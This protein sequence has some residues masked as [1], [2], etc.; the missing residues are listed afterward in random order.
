M[1]P[2]VSFARHQQ[3]GSNRTL[4][5]S[6]QSRPQFDATGF[7]IMT[8]FIEYSA[9]LRLYC[10]IFATIYNLGLPKLFFAFSALET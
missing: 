9:F 4:L 3:T 10:S 1:D 5:N 8:E 2:I 6:R 7:L